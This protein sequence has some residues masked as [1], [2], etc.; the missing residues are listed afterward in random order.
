MHVGTVAEI[1]ATPTW[2]YVGFS[3]NDYVGYTSWER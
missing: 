1:P 2:P 3:R